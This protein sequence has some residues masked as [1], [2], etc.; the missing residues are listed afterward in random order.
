[1]WEGEKMDIDMAIGELL[2]LKSAPKQPTPA[3]LD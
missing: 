3:G 2:R 1:M